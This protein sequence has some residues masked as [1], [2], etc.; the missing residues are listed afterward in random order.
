MDK[1]ARLF[2]FLTLI[3]VVLLAAE[4][5][6]QYVESLVYSST[7]IAAIIQNEGVYAALIHWGLTS[8]VWAT[9]IW[10]LYLV[11]KRNG[12]DPLKSQPSVPVFVWLLVLVIL[13]L[14]VAVSFNDWGARFKPIVEYE[15]MS[16]Q[17]GN[18]ALIAIIGQYIYYL[19]ESAVILTIIALGQKTGEL[20]FKLT[21]IPWGGLICALTLGV[22]HIFT[23]D[24]STGLYSAGFAV[25]YGII[26]LLLRKNVQYTYPVLALMFIL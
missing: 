6:V 20:A 9:G 23:K 3:A 11:A 16:T 5:A 10:L 22:A 21:F 8:A 12:F 26:Y 4:L 7:D 19:V 13:V 25:V 15:Y 18:Q 24:L 2:L 1:K 14:S 17:F